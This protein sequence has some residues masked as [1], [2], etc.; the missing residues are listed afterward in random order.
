MDLIRL[1]IAGSEIEAQLLQLELQ[2]RGI[3]SAVMGSMLAAGRGE[4][5]LTTQ[6]QPAIWIERNDA[7]R[8]MAALREARI[9]PM[10]DESG[11]E[12]PPWTCPQ[13]GELVEDRFAACWNCLAERPPSPED[14]RPREL[15]QARTEGV[16]RRLSCQGCGYDLRMLPLA[17][18]CPECGM[19]ILLSLLRAVGE[20]D[21]VNRPDL[22]WA[23]EGVAGACRRPVGA[24]LLVAQAW[25]DA[26]ESLETGGRGGEA[27]RVGA[28]ELC[29]ALRRRVWF[30]DD[31]AT[32]RLMRR[33]WRMT[34]PGDVGQ[35]VAAMIEGKMLDPALVAAPE[36]FERVHAAIVPAVRRNRARR[37]SLILTLVVLGLLLLIACSVLA[38]LLSLS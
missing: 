1:Y 28:E 3:R 19:P 23:A 27:P 31:V 6:T 2:R 11:E 35:V 9:S 29:D 32:A 14:D 21:Q 13:C 16:L 10:G 20:F 18:R 7:D 4:L 24:V 30:T 34:T 15:P 33:S 5:P 8:A 25:R 37:A 26:F 36:A 38:M 17:H 22:L 12:S